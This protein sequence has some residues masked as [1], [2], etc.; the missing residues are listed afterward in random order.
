MTASQLCGAADSADVNVSVDR[1]QRR[2][3]TS[4][5]GVI[6]TISIDSGKVLDTAILSKSC[7]GST[8]MQPIKA[9]DSRT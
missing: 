5:A 7:K 6:T 3:F 8:R 2:G 9:K 1:R 4:L